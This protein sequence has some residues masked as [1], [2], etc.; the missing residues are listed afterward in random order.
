MLTNS[1][2][3]I[4]TEGEI[5]VLARSPDAMRVLINHYDQVATSDRPSGWTK[6]TLAM[7]RNLIE[8][9]LEKALPKLEA[10][11]LPVHLATHQE[12]GAFDEAQARL[13]LSNPNE[14]VGNLRWMLY[15]VWW[16]WQGLDQAMRRLR[17][18]PWKTVE[19]PQA[20]PQP[21]AQYKDTSAIR[22]QIIDFDRRLVNAGSEPTAADYDSI[23]K[24][25]T[26][27]SDPAIRQEV[28]NHDE[29]MR[30]GKLKPTSEDYQ[31]IFS[32]V[33]GLVSS[34]DESPFP[35]GP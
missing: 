20:R 33:T 26:S 4:L 17:S 14:A 10:K 27:I 18:G 29:C 8:A 28:L 23:L 7:R 11:A 2:K 19:L 3:L 25:A 1:N 13:S 32:I 34:M 5:D 6:A 21:A 22:S 35:T 12:H 24:W 9:I 31:A 16:R 30:R 15:Q